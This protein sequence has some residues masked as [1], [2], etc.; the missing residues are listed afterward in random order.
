MI[1]SQ[2]DQPTAALAFVGAGS[3]GQAFAALL[4]AHG[5]PVTLFASPATAQALTGVGRIGLRGAVD[6]EA[7]V[8]PAPSPAGTVGVTTDP[9]QLPD[10]AGVIFCT[11]GHQLD[12]AMARVRAGWP[13]SGDTAAWVG[14]VQNGL[15]KD[16]RLAE[17]FGP[18]RVVGAVTILGAQREG[19]GAVAVAALGRTYLGELAGGISPRVE[20]AAAALN[21]AGIPT[22]ASADI[23][24]VLWSKACNA[25]G[26]FGVSVLARVSTP[27]LFRTPEL[28]RAYLALVRETAALGAAYGVTVGDYTNFPIRT[29][30]RRP[31]EATVEALMAQAPLQ[32]AATGGVESLPSMTQDLF[33][34][35]ALEVDAVFGDLV[36]R[37]ER[38]GVA[39]P[40]L[41]L[42]RDI[43]AGID[44]GRAR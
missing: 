23:Q 27:R 19:P 43:I 25:A 1:T 11:K 44:P 18:E 4:A 41:R 40:R 13:R 42:V 28:I 30:V 31:D 32:P 35:R 21:A 22:D 5:Q 36:A 39:V 34:G 37:A 12:E 26:V 14:G 16:D 2:P 29:Y 20:A 10:G 17:V 15:A 38:A 6:V 33:A 9:E 3:L 8:A 24:S 7:P